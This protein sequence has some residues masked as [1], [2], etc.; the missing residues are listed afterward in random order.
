MI[1]VI[2]LNLF[3]RVNLMDMS[4]LVNMLDLLDLVYAKISFCG[5]THFCRHNLANHIQGLW[6]SSPQV[7]QDWGVGRR[8]G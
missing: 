5:F 3:S 8:G 1:L 2:L 4:D 7:C 6:S